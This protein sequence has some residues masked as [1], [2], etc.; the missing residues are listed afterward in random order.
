M[1]V[2]AEAKP[3]DPVQGVDHVLARLGPSMTLAVRARDLSNGRRD[4]SIA[5]V[6]IDDRQ[7]EQ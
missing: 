5:S 4:P 6:F 3:E 7:F 1:S 2:L